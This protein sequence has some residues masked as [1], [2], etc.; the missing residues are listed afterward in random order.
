M[1]IRDISRAEAGADTLQEILD[2]AA[3][4]KRLAVV[5]PNIEAGRLMFEEILA[6]NDRSPDPHPLKAYR[7]RLEIKMSSGGRITFHSI[8]SLAG[9]RGLTLDRIYTPAGTTDEISSVWPCVITTGGH[10]QEYGTSGH[11]VI[12]N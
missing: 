6:G 7:A 1:S 9:M 8:R 10:I 4:G 3:I 11:E 5:V 12:R 2:A